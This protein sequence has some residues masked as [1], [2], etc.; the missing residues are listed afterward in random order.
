MELE[1]AAAAASINVA[2]EN[3]INFGTKIP[4]S[5]GMHK[6]V[7]TLIRSLQTVQV[8]L[9]DK[10]AIITNGFKQWLKKLG[11]VVFDAE[12]VVD[13]LKYHPLSKE[14]NIAKPSTIKAKVRTYLPSPNL[15]G[16]ERS[17]AQRIN[18]INENL[19]S[20]KN[21]GKILGPKG[22][23]VSAPSLTHASGETGSSLPDPV[24][25][26]KEDDVLELADWLITKT[27]KQTARVFDILAIQGQVGTGKTMLARKLFNHEC[28]K[29]RFDL[30]IWVNLDDICD[31]DDLLTKIL[32][33]FTSDQVESRQDILKRL[34]QA[35]IG[36]TC[37]LV[38][39]DAWDD[40]A[41]IWEDFLILMNGVISTMGNAIIIT[42]RDTDV[43]E[44]K[45]PFHIHQLK[46]L[47]VEECWSI[48]KNITSGK[49]NVTTDLERTGRMIAKRCMAL[50][51]VAYLVGGILHGKSQ[52]QWESMAEKLHS[53]DE[54]QLISDI[55]R[56][57]FLNL[58]TSSMKMCFAFCSIFPKGYEIVKQELIELWMAEGFLQ[59]EE[60]YDMESVGEKFLNVLVQK[61]MLQIADRGENGEVE[62]FM[63]QHLLH[64]LACSVS[65]SHYDAEDSIPV[66]YSNS[67]VEEGAKDLRTLLW[68]GE[69]SDSKLSD[70]PCLRTLSLTRVKELPSSVKKLIHLR[71]LNISKSRIT[72]LPE[73]IG[74]LRNLQTLRADTQSLTELPSTLKD[75]INLRH[76]YVLSDIKLPAEM[77]RLTN[78]RTLKHFVVGK[79]KGY[80]IEELEGLNNLKGEIHISNLENVCNEEET[81]KANIHQKLN[82]SELVFTWSEEREDGKINDESVLEGLQPHPNLK[83]LEIRGFKGKT[84]PLWTQ[85]MEVRYGSQGSWEPL[86]NLIQISLSS[87]SECEQIPKLEHLSNLKSLSLIGLKKVRSMNSLPTH[88]MSL[89]IHGLEILETLPDSVIHMNRDL[90]TL[91]IIGCPNLKEM[92]KPCDGG[93]QYSKRILRVLRIVDCGKL[94][95]IPYPMVESWAPSLEILELAKLLELANLPMVIGCVAKSSRLR[96]LKIAYVP[97]FITT[98]SVE[99]WHFGGLQKLTLDVSGEAD[100]FIKEKVNEILEGCC[101]SLTQ[102]CLQGNETSNWVPESI[103]DLTALSKLELQN[104]GIEELPEWFKKLS[105]LSQLSLSSCSKL[106][107][108]L[109]WEALECLTELRHLDV[110]HCPELQIGFAWFVIPH[111]T[112]KADKHIN[113]NLDGVMSFAANEFLINSLASSFKQEYSS[114]EDVK[115]LQTH[116]V[117]MQD[118]LNGTTKNSICKDFDVQIWLKDLRALAF[119]ADNVLD[120]LNY[121]AIDK[122][123]S[124]FSFFNARQPTKQTRQ[125]ISHSLMHVKEINKKFEH[126]IERANKLKLGVQTTLVTEPTASS[127]SVIPDPIFIGRGE[128]VDILVKKLITSIQEKA[129]SILAIVGKGGVGKET[130]TRE[131]LNHE[132]IKAR[133]GLHVWVHVS[134]ISHPVLLL[135]KILSMLTSET[136]IGGVETKESILKGLQQALKDKTYILVLVLDNVGYEDVKKWKIFIDLIP[137][138]TS[139]KGN[140]VI[141]TTKN[142]EVASLVDSHLKHPLKGLSD[143]DCWFI[144]KEKAFPNEDVQSEYETVGREIAKVCQGLPLA[145]NVVGGVLEGTSMEEWMV[146]KENCLSDTGKAESISNILKWSFDRL[147]SS[148]LKICFAYCSIFPKGYK[149]VKQ[150]LIELWI[151]EQF[152]QPNGGNDM[153]SEGD[154]LSN[155]LVHNSFLQVAERDRYGNVLSFV[156]HD[157]MHDLA[158]ALQK[159]LRSLDDT[160]RYLLHGKDC[161][162]Y[163]TEDTKKSLRTLFFQGE[164]HDTM[165]S[166]C[167]SLRALSLDCGRV[168]ELPS[169]IRELIHLRN[170]NV[171]RT[172]I[173]Y[174]PDW[175]SELRYLQTINASTESLRKLPSTLKY[176]ISLRHLYL[177][178]GVELPAEI[179]RLTDLQE[180]K[181][182]V[183]KDKGYR[184]EELECLYNLKQLSIYNLEKVRGKEEA[185]KAK[186]SQK[187]NL[188]KLSFEWDVD[189]KGEA[190]NDVAVLR[191]LEPHPGLK[192]LKIAGFAGKNFPSWVEKMVVGDKPLIGLIEITLSGCQ[193]CEEIPELGQLPNLKILNLRSLSKVTCIKSSFYGNNVRGDS[194]PALETL[195]LTGMSELE[196]IEDVGQKVRVFPRLVSLKIYWCHKLECLPSRLFLQAHGLKEMDVRN[197]SKLS[198][199]PYHLD[200]LDSL[201][202]LTIK[203]CQNLELIVSP[204]S[205]GE[206]KSLCSLEISECQK[207]TEIVKPRAPSLKKVS[208]VELKSLQNLSKF[209]DSLKQYTPFLAQLA[210]VGVPKFIS[211]YPKWNLRHLRKL[212]IDVSMELSGKTSDDMRKTSDDMGKTVGLMLQSCRLSLGELKLTGLEIWDVLPELIQLLTALYSLELENFGVTVLPKWFKDLSCL[213][214]LCLSNFPKLTHLPS[215]KHFTEL[216]EFHICNCPKINME[217]EGLKIVRS[218]AIYVNRDPL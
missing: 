165:F 178:H 56:L 22:S 20:I 106:K 59:P 210:I 132:D 76:L 201:E 87:C 173:E 158:S 9:C 140:A 66:R 96:E 91:E 118:Y 21:E 19:E 26:E 214:K 177:C 168:K 18:E 114:N 164:I 39:D 208:I 27:T 124:S 215:M 38:L 185:Q 7:Q 42:T 125:G 88:L 14:T 183:G 176:L 128:D 93:W 61:S 213:K 169:S 53:Q 46:S 110:K 60:G 84:F 86:K 113:E 116:L 203:G 149:I 139:T 209:L 196:K 197:C 15:D 111:L 89:C 3:V 195:L 100:G 82:L 160:P 77:G 171:S 31:S 166:T 179:G 4:E 145:A 24:F 83:K 37:L 2:I 131:V 72:Q 150:E 205:R 99:S 152:L 167:E 187:R 218:C 57:S 70:Y 156:M 10:E 105:S 159:I 74:K 170:L 191:G 16:T 65:G 199:L 29:A 62:S 90:S 41:W 175:I 102:L 95:E 11:P 32:A 193:G 71:N 119:N 206:L 134:R 162:S 103:Q 204:N 101:K 121:R 122:V 75:L 94:K 155:V 117:T 51:L 47:T 212:E 109:S 55:L 200:T 217:Y 184:I 123:Q 78:L 154:T 127:Y 129:I 48:I 43:A 5:S 30:H 6:N 186:L 130:L 133:F 194:F 35:F 12:N 151:A 69:I 192:M 97:E 153:E 141:I 13:E 107:H 45:M 98:H 54:W 172:G 138:V 68:E 36:K 44:I 1:A 198:A 28:I 64:D 108:L 17:L 135:K 147:L 85:K 120:E 73:W 216:Q 207:L 81:A 67:T 163:I 34:Q 181:F 157:L 146:F 80:Q 23:P 126:M 79:D 104:F 211:Y 40:D 49:Q 50:P 144:I 143:E 190:S 142:S 182:G 137:K 52:E 180:L 25:V 136:N 58:S 115:H 202:S 8:S 188:A 174:L 148:S 33:T 189:R 63:M 112:I 92:G 161:S